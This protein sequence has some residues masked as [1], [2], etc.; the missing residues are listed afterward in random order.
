M[1][2]WL[3]C[4]LSAPSSHAAVSHALAHRSMPSLSVCLFFCLCV[5]RTLCFCLFLSMYLSVSPALCHSLS[6]SIS[7]YLSRSLSRFLYRSLPHRMY[8][9]R[10]RFSVCFCLCLVSLCSI[11]THSSHSFTLSFCVGLYIYLCL[12]LVFISSWLSRSLFFVRARIRLYIAVCLSDSR[13]WIKSH[14]ELSL[15]DSVYLSVWL[16]RSLCLS[17]S[18]CLWLSLYLDLSISSYL[19]TCL[20]PLSLALCLPRCV[21]KAARRLLLLCD[22]YVAYPTDPFPCNDIVVGLRRNRGDPI[23]TNSLIWSV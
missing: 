7:L 18:L 22:V 1:R 13:H 8:H 15:C 5:C 11:M 6:F 2:H 16:Y 3:C 19:S 12:C 21:F 14:L 23:Q 4:A 17:V 20:Y 9:Y 10:Y